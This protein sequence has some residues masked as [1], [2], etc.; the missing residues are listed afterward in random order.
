VAVAAR[1]LLAGVFLWSGLSMLLDS[2]QSRILSVAAYDVVPTSLIRPLAM[3]LPLL[4]I[5]LGLLLLLGLFTRFA[6]VTT[7][8]LLLAF[9]GAMAQ[10][11]ARGLRIDCGCFGAGGAGTGVTWLDILRD[12]ALLAAAGLLASRPR[13]PFSIDGYMEQ[14]GVPHEG[15]N[16]DELRWQGEGLGVEAPRPR[17]GA[18]RS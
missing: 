17:R 1:L 18:N 9:V 7:G 8:V 2:Q 16:E 4:E 11:K 12:V 14:K 15:L 13:T 5:T 10:A 3:A 6:A